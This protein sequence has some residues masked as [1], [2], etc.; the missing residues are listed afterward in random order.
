MWVAIF[1]LLLPLIIL[2]QP[3]YQ[4]LGPFELTKLSAQIS[5]LMARSSGSSVDDPVRRSYQ[6]KGT[7]KTARTIVLHRGFGGLYSGFSYHLC[8]FRIYQVFQVKAF[9]WFCLLVRDT[10]GTAIYFATYESFKQLL[11]K[12]QRSSSPTSPLSVAV[13]GGL[14]G[15]VSWAC[16]SVSTELG[17]LPC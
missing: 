13:A 8:K 9:L 12:F 7:F 1:L 15:L 3:S 4:A 17:Q 11:V 6:Q 5:E 10:I 14:C 16:V 2:D